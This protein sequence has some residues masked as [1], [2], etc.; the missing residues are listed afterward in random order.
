V[1]VRHELLILN[2]GRKREPNLRATDR[3]IAALC[4]L[5]TL[6]FIHFVFSANAIQAAGF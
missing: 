2:R 4:T 3:I 1:L 5:F 6:G